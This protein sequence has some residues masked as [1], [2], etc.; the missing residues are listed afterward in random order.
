MAGSVRGVVISFKLDIHSSWSVV[1][2]TNNISSEMGSLSNF[3]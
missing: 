2:I 3:R 1:L